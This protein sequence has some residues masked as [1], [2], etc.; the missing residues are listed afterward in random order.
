[1]EKKRVIVYVDGFNFYYGLK[2]NPAWK[3]YYWLDLVKFFEMFMKPD[4][5]LIAVKYFSAR[6]DDEGKSRNQ[7]A[8]FQANKENSKFQ[9]ILGKYLQKEIKCFKCGYTIKTHEEKES[10]VRI[11]TQIVSDVYRNNCDISI[12][13][14]ADSDMVPA[15]EIAIEEN[16]PIY[17]Y[18]PP[19]Q[20]S[21]NLRTKCGKAIDLS[22]YESRFKQCILPDTIH[23]RKSNFDLQ[24]PDKWKQYQNQT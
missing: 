3:K 23:L 13:V 14:S 21:S 1:M 18:F 10:D 17:V 12:V 20:H 24:I 9:L 7:N 2:K 5:E 4:Q 15:V 8:M 19:F 11:A 6:P 22:R 16:H